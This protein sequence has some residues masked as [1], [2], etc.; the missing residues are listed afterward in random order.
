[1]HIDWDDP[2]AR[3]ALIESVGVQEYNRQ[4][5]EH[6]SRSALETINGHRIRA[7]NSRFGRILMVGD[8]GTGFL[9]LEAARAFA[10]KT[11][12]KKC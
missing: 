9:T 8:T 7:V 2:A 5:E 12:P 3:L 6:R 10:L 11:E 1:M 4:A